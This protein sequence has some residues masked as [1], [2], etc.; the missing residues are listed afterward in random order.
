MAVDEFQAADIRTK[1]VDPGTGLGDVRI[2]QQFVIFQFTGTT[3][4][5]GVGRQ[6]IVAPSSTVISRRLEE[7]PTYS[8]HVP[9]PVGLCPGNNDHSLPSFARED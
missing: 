8:Y 1:H 5:M 3:V 6:C 7:C 2:C 4:L 9:H